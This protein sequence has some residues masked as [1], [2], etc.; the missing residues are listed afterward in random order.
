MYFL[1]LSFLIIHIKGLED[2]LHE[3]VTFL[4]NNCSLELTNDSICYQDS[5]QFFVTSDVH[6]DDSQNYINSGYF[7]HSF[8]ESQFDDLV[9][10]DWFD[11]VSHAKFG[12]FGIEYYFDNSNNNIYL[13]D[14]V[15]TKYGYNCFETETGIH[16]YVSVFSKTH[17]Y[18]L[19]FTNGRLCFATYD[20]Q[21]DFDKIAFYL[22]I[23]HGADKFYKTAYYFGNV[24]NSEQV[25]FMYNGGD[26]YKESH[27]NISCFG[28]GFGD[29]DGGCLNINNY[30][31][32]YVNSS[33]FNEIINLSDDIENLYL[34]INNLTITTQ[35]IWD[36]V[37]NMID[38][39]E[40][41]CNNTEILEQ[42]YIFEQI[43][44]TIEIII[45]EL[46]NRT[47]GDVTCGD[48][49]C[50]NI[51]IIEMI[52]N[53][54]LSHIITCGN[55]VT[56]S[57][58]VTCGNVTCGNVTCGNNVTCSNVTCGNVTCGNV[59]CSNVTC[60]NV[61]CSNV[62]CS[63]V[64]CSNVTCSNVT[65][66]NVTCSNVTCDNTDIIEI[67][68]NGSVTCGDVTCDNTEIFEF[69]SNGSVTCGDI[70]DITCG[71]V[72]YDNTDIIEIMKNGSLTC[73]NIGEIGNVTCSNIGEIGN[74]TCSNVTCDNTDIIEIM[75]NGSVTCG[76]VTCDNTEIFE[77]LSNG[78]V[79]CGDIGEIG[80]ITCACDEKLDLIIEILNNKTEQ[81]EGSLNKWMYL[82]HDCRIQLEQ[83]DKGY[84][85][86]GEECVLA[87]CNSIS[88]LSND[89][90]SGHG[91]CVYFNQCI[92][93]DGWI[94]KYCDKEDPC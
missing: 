45:I 66:S 65:C 61:T 6:V 47:C 38:F 26:G 11:S 93:E 7:N 58:N 8:D 76:N 73:G 52:K 81:C 41:N 28:F 2:C 55:N 64:T 15:T 87:T 27:G 79:T 84:Y 12:H 78:S 43:L 33:F 60:S 39:V 40:G 20:L 10:E 34:S 37:I 29:G 42:S 21:F 46:T 59:T 44:E 75:K 57:N 30:Y 19:L 25:M 16:K 18:F 89:A 54:T 80:E 24:L 68:K 85:F 71:N 74:V 88:L 62:T 32:Y 1:I 70:G 56:C 91:A 50:D 77:F 92:C 3:K 36:L 63:N 69:L 83:C 90:C 14:G 4:F 31:N 23:S 13:S 35:N 94:G 67:M 48:C 72:T 86:N 9:V 82:Y 17:G 49:V 53:I 5:F 22:D 51:N